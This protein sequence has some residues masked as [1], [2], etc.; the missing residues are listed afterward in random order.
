MN[1]YLGLD[2]GGTRTRAFICNA[3]ASSAAWG[4]AGLSNP[5]HGRPDEAQD[6]LRLAIDRALHK[7]GIS[8][9]DCSSVFA[10]IAGV[11]TEPGRA[12]MREL[13][14][15]CGLERSRIE[16]DHD[17]RIALAGGLAGK[18]GIA[19]IVGTG[20]SCY[21]RAANG[22]T[23][24]TGGW[25]PLISD[26]GSAYDLAREAIAATAR[27]ADGRERE[28]PLRAEVFQWLGIQ[29]IADILPRM[30]E[31][32]LTRSEIAAFAPRVI[33]LASLG[34]PVATGI[35]D[36]GATL[37]AEMV[38]GNHRML[39]TGPLPEVVVTG[40]LGTR[41]GIYRRKLIDAIIARLPKA[42]VHQPI[43]PP[44]LGAALLASEN[45]GERAS[46]ELLENLKRW[47]AEAKDAIQ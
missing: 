5:N 44:V 47:A 13:I 36:R 39:P 38:A 12:R 43:L 26:E 1:Y 11:T 14:S 22:Q 17:I 18:P 23:W 20:S 2:G 24:Q 16:V 4:E 37:L 27:I 21:G 34:D 32:A 41:E 33:E 29:R 25:E 15:E 9:A 46:T 7:L 35:L 6:N 10:G 31:K 42:A 3:S 45:S 40:G 30:Q 28:S 8:H 19:L